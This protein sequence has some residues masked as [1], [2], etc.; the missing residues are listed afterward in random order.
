MFKLGRKA[1]K[2]NQPDRTIG[3]DGYRQCDRHVITQFQAIVERESN[4]DYSAL[5]IALKRA[6]DPNFVVT[7]INLRAAYND[8]LYS[9]AQVAYVRR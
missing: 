5:A 7:M 1:N 4:C 8:G 6:R 9:S 2:P 3:S